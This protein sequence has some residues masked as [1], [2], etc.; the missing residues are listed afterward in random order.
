MARMASAQTNISIE[1]SSEICLWHAGLSS[2][3]APVWI[4]SE[5]DDIEAKL[6]KATA[7]EIE[8]MNPPQGGPARRQLLQS[9]LA[10]RFQ[11][12]VHRRDQRRLLL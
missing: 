1:V 10:D 7:D 4:R 12:K 5:S 11:L 9:L 3:G 6:N 2:C 8:K